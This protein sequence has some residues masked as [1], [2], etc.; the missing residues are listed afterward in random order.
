MAFPF[1]LQLIFG[2]PR[3]GYIFREDDTGFDGKLIKIFLMNPPISCKLLKV[4]RVTRL[5]A[6]DVY[7]NVQV[8]DALTG[9]DVSKR[10]M[11]EIST[12][13]SAKDGRVSLPPSI[14]AT[15]VTLVK[16]Q[17]DTNS[18]MLLGKEQ[19]L[20]LPKGRY[21]FSFQAGLDGSVVIFKQLGILN[22]GDT[23]A[24]LHWDEKIMNKFFM[25]D[26]KI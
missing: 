25:W 17:R 26:E 3:I 7:L 6:Q 10:F 24:E 13:Q 12:S 4:L 2:Q 14:F 16:W 20:V 8:S 1:F 19:S 22:V 9:Q 5:T 21:L 11:L 23:E 15:W 18:A